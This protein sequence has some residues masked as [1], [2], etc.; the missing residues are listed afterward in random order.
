[1]ENSFPKCGIEVVLRKMTD[2]IFVIEPQRRCRIEGV[3]AWG[4]VSVL[5]FSSIKTGICYLTETIFVRTE[6]NN[7]I[8]KTFQLIANYYEKY[9]LYFYSQN[10]HFSVQVPNKVMSFW[11]VGAWLVC[12]FCLFVFVFSAATRYC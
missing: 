7:S 11:A 5:V 8:L 12:M 4:Y 10:S 1:M 6:Q 2:K 9:Q 3:L